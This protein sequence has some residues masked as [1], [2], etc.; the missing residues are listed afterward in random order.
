LLL[1]LELL[2]PFLEGAV[3]RSSIFG[4]LTLPVR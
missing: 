3:M 2:Q 4:M 1:G